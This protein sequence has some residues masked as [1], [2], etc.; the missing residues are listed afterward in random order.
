LGGEVEVGQGPGLGQAG[1]PQPAGQP[2]GLGGF[3]L[4]LQQPFQRGGQ[5]QLL[6]AGLVQHPR[7]L[8]GGGV[9][10]EVVQV[11]AQLLVAARLAHR[12][13]GGAVGH[14]VSWSWS[15]SS[16][17]VEGRGRRSSVAAAWA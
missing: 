15:G 4:Q 2:A 14:G 17:T 8:L 5:R 16:D 13:R 6:D 3:D 11:G 10:L 12:R 9:E 7:Q 1:E